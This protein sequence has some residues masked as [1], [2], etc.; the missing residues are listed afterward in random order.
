MERFP[1]NYIPRG[2]KKLKSRF[3]SLLSL[4]HLLEK[5]H[6]TT[7]RGTQCSYFHLLQPHC[8][9]QHL[10]PVNVHCRKRRIQ[11]AP[12]PCQASPQMDCESTASGKDKGNGRGLWR[13]FRCLL[14]QGGL[15]KSCEHRRRKPSRILRSGFRTEP[16]AD[17]KLYKESLLQHFLTQELQAQGRC[18]AT[19]LAPS[20]TVVVR[21]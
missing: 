19:D 7:R 3:S 2:T 13:H 1:K 20:H 21:E 18:V 14:P 4:H 8:Q 11:G 6:D 15:L 17:N 16:F 9:F 10:H 5:L 12:C